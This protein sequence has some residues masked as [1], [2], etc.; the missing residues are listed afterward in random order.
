MNLRDSEFMHKLRNSK[1]LLNIFFSYE[2]SIWCK[3]ITNWLTGS[4]TLIGKDA[5]VRFFVSYHH[6]HTSPVAPS[7]SPSGTTQPQWTDSGSSPNHN[8]RQYEQISRSG[9]RS[10]PGAFFPPISSR[11]EIRRTRER[12]VAWIQ[13]GV[14]K[15]LKWA[16]YHFPLVYSPGRVYNTSSS[17][18]RVRDL[19]RT[20]LPADRP[21]NQPK[22]AARSMVCHVTLPFRF[23]AILLI[24]IKFYFY[25]Y[26]S[27]VYGGNTS[28]RC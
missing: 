6:H 9:F 20:T 16:S 14:L 12:V 2:L 4:M 28:R 10:G 19:H 26:S 25:F 8:H 7:P 23:F 15:G 11:P 5:N 18:S 3:I 21:T 13:Q 22:N 17:A 1:I 27:P 24:L